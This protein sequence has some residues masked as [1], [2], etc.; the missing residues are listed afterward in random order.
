MKNN[1]LPL[2]KK[3][4]GEKSYKRRTRET[5]LLRIVAFFIAI[6]LWVFV[7]GGKQVEVTKEV[8]LEYQLP[9]GVAFG[10]QPP[11]SISIKV[12]G[13]PVFL[14]EFQDSKISINL[15]LKNQ[16][17]G[18]SEIAIRE[19]SLNLPLGLRLTSLSL[20]SIKVRLERLTV[21]RVPLRPSFAPGLPPEYKISS[22][23]LR[24]S[25]IEIKGP[26]SRIQGIEALPTEPITLLSSSLRQEVTV[27]V[28]LDGHNGVEI[29]E[30]ERS[31]QVVIELE[32]NLERR[33]VKGLSVGV[34]VGTGVRQTS[35]D[36][37]LLGIR[38]RPSK[39]SFLLEGPARLIEELKQGGLEV[40]G[41]IPEI[42]PGTYTSRPI[43]RLPPD[44]RVVKRSADSIEVT[45]PKPG[46]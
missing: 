28:Q 15:D 27:G 16:K 25:T 20:S 31:V 46:V 40:W 5:W 1:P 36:T 41:E 17:S 8:F 44:V 14:R 13:P 3:L 32:G 23:T 2:W 43:W 35:L 21:K 24:P 37:Q 22:V 33:W 30:N 9:V 7:L 45:I 12:S 18:E 42:K 34:K 19:D 4:V 39:V 38:V 6:V 10:N 26:Q 11:K 29:N